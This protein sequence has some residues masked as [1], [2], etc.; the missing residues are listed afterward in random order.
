MSELKKHQYCTFLLDGQRFG[1]AVENVQEVIRAQHMTPVPL[2][3]PIIRGLINLRGQIVIALDPRRRLGFPE[4][5]PGRLPINVVIRR[6][7][8]TVSLLVDE[9]GEVVTADP[10]TF[11]RP[12][13]TIRK[14]VRD[15]LEGLYKLND[16]LLLI[17]DLERF[18]NI[19]T[20]GARQA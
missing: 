6:G 1:V 15:V 12:P 16:R 17:L 10:S 4:G 14:E 20:Q 11:E 18:F 3:T 2:T 9:V 13:E 8:G 5:P 19:Q 7:E